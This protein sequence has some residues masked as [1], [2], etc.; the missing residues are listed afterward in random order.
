MT[1]TGTVTVPVLTAAATADKR[2][3]QKGR[4]GRGGREGLVSSSR[5]GAGFVRNSRVVR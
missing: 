4:E 2:E 5:L 1:D 3:L